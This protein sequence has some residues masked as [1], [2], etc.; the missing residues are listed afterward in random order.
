MSNY[1][2]K[3]SV[4]SLINLVMLGS[5]VSADIEGAPSGEGS[6]LRASLREVVSNAH[7]K[8]EREAKEVAVISAFAFGTYHVAQLAE[9]QLYSY[10][11]LPSTAEAMVAVSPVSY[12]VGM[13][14]V[15]VGKEAAPAVVDGLEKV[16]PYVKPLS[17]VYH[18]T[19]GWGLVK[20]GEY[21]QKKAKSD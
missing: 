7:E 16:A 6:S 1:I 20:V 4:A 9:Y 19:V 11:V 21:M 14:G 15:Y 10:V 17:N 3:L 13:V 2:A 18:A 8:V 12:L 5:S